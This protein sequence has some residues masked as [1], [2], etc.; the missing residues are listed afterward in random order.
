MIILRTRNV[1]RALPLGIALLERTGIRQS[2]RG[3]KVCYES[4]EPVTTVYARPQERVVFWEARDANPFFHL[5]ESLHMLAGRRDVAWLTYYNARMREFSD[6]GVTFHGAYGHRWR[7]AF[8]RD[9]LVALI[10][11]LQRE[12]DTRRAVLQM[13][14]APL[15]LGM[16]S[17]D[18]PCNTHAYFKVRD[19]AL[20]MLVCCRSNDV[21]W[22]TYGAN[23]V[24]FSML[25]EYLADRL[26]VRVGPYTQVSDSFHAYE[27]VWE[28]LHGLPAT[29]LSPYEA[30]T[31][32]PF[33]LKAEEP[34]WD[35]DLQQAFVDPAQACRTEF[36]A[37]VFYP[38]FRAF[39]SY[40]GGEFGRAF[41]QVQACLAS[42]WALAA[43]EWLERRP[44]FVAATR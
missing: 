28:K 23:A 38:L 43:R 30:G 33:P 2:S 29:Q 14:H 24:H 5:F 7:S 15:D 21:V 1:H 16:D 32:A 39:E 26:E 36:F 37:G 40:K 42:D 9:Q 3:G 35:E 25:Q 31:V 6:D 4:P 27:G 17:L 12:P 13:W 41:A 10:Q 18:L 8:D 22:G 19:G 11:L 34:G 44:S 20:R